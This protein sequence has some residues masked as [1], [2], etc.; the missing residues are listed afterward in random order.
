MVIGGKTAAYYINAATNRGYIQQLNR[1]HGIKLDGYSGTKLYATTSEQGFIDGWN[2]ELV[3]LVQD[4]IS[5]TVDC[6]LFDTLNAISKSRKTAIDI[7]NGCFIDRGV[8]VISRR[9]GFDTDIE[10]DIW[11]ARNKAEEIQ[12]EEV[13]MFGG[14]RIARVFPRKTKATP[15][16]ALA[17]APKS[18]PKSKKPFYRLDQ[19]P[20]PPLDLPAVDEVHISVAFT[21]D[22]ENALYLR[23]AWSVLG[24]PVLMGGPAFNEPGGEFV[25]G[26]YLK[27]GYV[28][29]SR[30]CDNRCP[31]CKVPER[32]GYK[33]NQLT[34]NDGWNILDDNL[35]GC[36]RKHIEAVFDMLERHNKV[37]EAKPYKQRK[38]PVFTGGLEAR[39][40]EPWHVEQ[41]KRVKAKTMYFAYDTPEEY[42]FLVEAGKILRA[43]GYTAVSQAAR[44]YVLIGY[45]DDTK[46]AAEERLI[47]T[48]KAGFAPYAMLWMDD[49]G[50]M[51]EDWIAFRRTW[52]SF[53]IA[54]VQYME[55]LPQELGGAARG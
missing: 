41:F 14:K 25:P 8:R 54:G 47:A 49:N 15:T 51:N 36:S 37:E 5:G 52:T 18:A 19:L 26:L 24:V 27:Q 13:P 28:I 11:A 40:L 23:D 2:D 46:E 21:G 32:E 10:N 7:I 3:R 43:G 33:L 55:H 16:D 31:N 48:C 22:M 1:L 50:E 42:A 12:V 35:L 4:V 39:L 9:E 34:I 45:K 30:G 44:C 6:I 17:F 53:T 38:F 20:L 29:T